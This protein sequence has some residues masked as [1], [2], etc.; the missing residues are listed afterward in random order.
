MSKS[1]YQASLNQIARR[2]AALHAA[3]PLVAENG[4]PEESDAET[5]EY[6]VLSRELRAIDLDGSEAAVLDLRDALALELGRL[7]RAGR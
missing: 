4:G 7:E 5:F 3:D 6:S 2:L 1:A